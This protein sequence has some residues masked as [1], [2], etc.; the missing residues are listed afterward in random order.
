MTLF[1]NVMFVAV[2]VALG[3][4]ISENTVLQLRLVSRIWQVKI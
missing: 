1:V 4:V 3:T 2:W